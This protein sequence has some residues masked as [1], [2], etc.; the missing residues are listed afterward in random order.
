MFLFIV[1]AVRS[2]TNKV[3]VELDDD[4]ECQRS[5]ILTIA[6]FFNCTFA[7]SDFR[8]IDSC[9]LCDE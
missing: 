4:R 6:A 8:S 9:K 3:M 1:Q 7:M 5:V 2:I